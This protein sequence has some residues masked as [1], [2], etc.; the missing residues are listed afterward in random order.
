MKKKL[1]KIYLTYY[2]ILL[3]AQDLW[4][5]HYQILSIIFLKEFMK[6]NV[7]NDKNWEI[8]VIKYTYCSCLLKD[9]NFKD[10][11]TE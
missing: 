6:L 8:W 7:K 10:E 9:T 11:L 3:V 1:Q 2:N 5:A 4:R